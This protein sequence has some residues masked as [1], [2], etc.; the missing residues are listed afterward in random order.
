MKVVCVL[1][2]D[3]RSKKSEVKSKKLREKLKVI[4]KKYLKFRSFLELVLDS[5]LTDQTVSI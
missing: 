1:N 2:S 4:S 5:L 3:E